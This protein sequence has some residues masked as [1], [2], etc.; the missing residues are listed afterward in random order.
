MPII[1][2]LKRGKFENNK[3]KNQKN[4]SINTTFNFIPKVSVKISN[5]RVGAVRS[6]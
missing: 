4:K 6:Y 5:L 3:T 2:L 1:S